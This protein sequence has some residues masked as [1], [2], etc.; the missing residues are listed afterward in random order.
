[1]I[2]EAE[3]L[4]QMGSI[5]LLAF[6]AATLAGKLNQSV[7][8]GYIIIGALI[9]PKMSLE[10]FGFEYHGLIT[11]TSIIELLSYV[12]LVMLMF[13]VGLEFSFTKL[14]KTRTPAIILAVIDTRAGL[15]VG[16]IFASFLGWPLIDSIFLA[17]V[18]AMSS[19]SIAM[20]ILFDLKRMSSPEV[21]FLIG[22][23]VVETFI[24]LLILTVASGMTVEPAANPVG[25]GQLIIGIVAFY[26]FFVWMA[27]WA[28]PRR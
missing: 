21:E 24:A 5:M 1:M 27:I 28:A 6:I 16:F 22:L 25:Y 9:G 14:K 26:G 19:T 8:I 7:M 11:D 23:V 13:F 12:G 10:I 17:G 20:K 3:L 18:L 4:F 15:F 2:N